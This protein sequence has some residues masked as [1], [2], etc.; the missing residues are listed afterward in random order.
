MGAALRPSEALVGSSELDLCGSS[1]TVTCS[2]TGARRSFH[3]DALVGKGGMAR[4][5]SATDANGTRVALKVLDREMSADPRVRSRFLREKDIANLVRHPARVPIDLAG[6]TERDDAVLVMELVEGENLEIVRR[7]LGGKLPLVPALRIAEEALEFLAACHSVGILHRDMKTANLLW[8]PGRA[9]RIVDFGIAR[10]D[11]LAALPELTLGTPSFMA[12][13]QAGGLAEED[14]RTDVF[15]VGAVLYTILLGRRL[16]RGRTH[17]ESLF[18]AATQ[19][20]PKVDDDTIPA[21]I[22]AVVDRALSFQRDDRFPS[23]LAMRDAVRPLR[24][25]EEA[26]SSIPPID[27][28]DGLADATP[29]LSSGSLVA[30]GRA[31]DAR[32]TFLD[33]PL[34]HLLMHVLARDLDGTL[35]VAVGDQREVVEFLSGAPIRRSAAATDDPIV[36]TLHRIAQMPAE[37]AY[38]FYVDDRMREAL[39]NMPWTR[40]EPL[41]AILTSTRRI[42]ALPAFRTRMRAT[43]ERLAARPLALHPAAAPA[44]FGLSPQERAVLDAALQFELSYHE[45]LEANVAPREVVDPLLY[46]L[47]ITRHLQTGA[48]DAWPVG[49]PR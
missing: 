18:L 1:L 2:A 12:P 49:V 23:A 25:R 45:L 43:L 38:R 39:G 7:R 41:D 13:E 31:P 15:G 26:R 34:P 14:P 37:A 27:A 32:G 40:V 3:V 17:D 16:H 11:P 47:G 33:T 44:R 42:R 21:E 4:V 19:H 9:I 35:I 46:A 5:Y 30:S 24:Q 6:T 48:V 36:G 8:T 28:D 20:A 29:S 10:C 22:A